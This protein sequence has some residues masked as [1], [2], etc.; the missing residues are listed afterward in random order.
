MAGIACIFPSGP[1]F[2]SQVPHFLNNIFLQMIQCTCQPKTHHTPSP[3][4]TPDG[5]VARSG[6][7][8][9]K[10]HHKSSQRACMGSQNVNWVSFKWA[11]EI[12][13]QTPN[14]R[15]N[16]STFFIL[17]FSFIYFIYDNCFL[18]IPPN[19]FL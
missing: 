15:P 4:N 17:F 18:L 3:I 10:E 16:F 6:G 2:E 13:I 9:F 19:N 11:S 8:K 1:G 7:Q 14:I 12:S 5:Q